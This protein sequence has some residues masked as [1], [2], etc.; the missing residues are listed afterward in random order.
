MK[1]SWG[2][3][4]V[5]A[6]ALLLFVPGCQSGFPGSH[7]LT[8]KDM[9]PILEKLNMPE[10]RVL[11][12]RKS[13]VEGLWEAGIENKGQRFVVYVDSSKRFVTPGP[14][15]DYVNRKDVTRERADELNKDRRVDISKL[16]LRDALV[17]GK[18]DA[19][20]DVVVFT[21]PG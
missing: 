7:G 12:I 9:M 20:I 15:I 19:P 14:L 6:F 18:A 21:D 17:V 4:P 11:A 10:A 8:E 16:S 3:V 5:I 1:H 2:R 13:P